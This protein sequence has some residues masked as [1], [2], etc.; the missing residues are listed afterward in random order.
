VSIAESIELGRRPMEKGA[1]RA[2]DMPSDY[3]GNGSTTSQYAYGGYNEPRFDLGA[4][5]Y[6]RN[7]SLYTKIGHLKVRCDEHKQVSSHPP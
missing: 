4:D 1:G 2:H 6:R 5:Q 3:G 7:S